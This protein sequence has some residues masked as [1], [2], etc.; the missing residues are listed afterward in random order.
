MCSRRPLYANEGTYQ[1]C[2]I[3]NWISQKNNNETD[4]V[5]ARYIFIHFIHRLQNTKNNTRM[6]KD[7]FN[8]KASFSLKNIA[9]C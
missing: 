1:N 4:Y 6:S 8:E 2:R 7:I 9:L 3:L 5:S